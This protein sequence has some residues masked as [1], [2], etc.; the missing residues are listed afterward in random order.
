MDLNKLAYYIDPHYHFEL[1]IEPNMIL[2]E[3]K[4]IL[5]NY[6]IVITNYTINCTIY[7][8]IDTHGAKIN[9]EINIYVNNEKYIVEF[10]RLS[11]DIIEF[12]KIYNEIKQIMIDKKHALFDC[13]I[14]KP[15]QEHINLDDAYVISKKELKNIINTFI[16]MINNYSHEALFCL[17]DLLLEYKSRPDLIDILIQLKVFEKI[18]CE[19]IQLQL[20]IANPER[21]R[22]LLTVLINISIVLQQKYS[23][24]KSGSPRA[25][26]LETDIEFLNLI[27]KSYNVPEILRQAKRLKNIWN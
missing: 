1:I 16:S 7:L 15:I 19:Y 4:N 21:V 14:T 9:F 17:S 2:K 20:G 6:D 11:G 18:Y 23:L 12:T 26:G 5:K 22:G 3:F 10:N 25:S 24:K 8:G 27:L 13:N